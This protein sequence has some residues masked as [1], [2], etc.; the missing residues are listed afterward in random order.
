MRQLRKWLCHALRPLLGA[1]AVLVF[2][3]GIAA[4]QPAPAAKGKPTTGKTEG[5][6]VCP[7]SQAPGKGTCTVTIEC[8]A[9][10]PQGKTV[11]KA[12]IDCPPPPKKK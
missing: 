11:C 1:A 4:A 6:Q 9:L 10:N 5:Q 2:L 12:T 3:G 8:P 7:P